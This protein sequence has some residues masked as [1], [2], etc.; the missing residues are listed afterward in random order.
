MTD[1][2]TPTLAVAAVKFKWQKDDKSYDYL[3][4]TGLDLSPGDKV[5]VE[6]R[7]GETEVEI[8]EI[9]AGSDKATTTILRRADPVEPTAPEA[10][11]AEDW[12]F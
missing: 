2:L 7:R 1:L 11:P 4:P 6:T 3:V 12:N 5:I 8:V 10:K 9:K